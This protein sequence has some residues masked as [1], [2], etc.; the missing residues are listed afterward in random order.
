M[1]N[2]TGSLIVEGARTGRQAIRVTLVDS[3]GGAAT[4]ADIGGAAV[5]NTPDQYTI[6][7][8][9]GDGTTAPATATHFQF[10]VD[11]NDRQSYINGANAYDPSSSPQ[12][13]IGAALGK[14]IPAGS[15]LQITGRA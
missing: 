7:D 6:L 14:V 11:G 9:I 2:Q 15:N 13:R 4:F 1:A 5:F 3:D 8:F 12:G 10:K